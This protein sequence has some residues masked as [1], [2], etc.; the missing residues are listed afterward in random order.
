[1]EGLPSARRVDLPAPDP[2]ALG[3]SAELEA[4]LS[5]NRIF[6]LV[7][8]IFITSFNAARQ[9]GETNILLFPVPFG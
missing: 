5:S 6:F 9:S 8:I 7:A 3:A 2:D 4:S 1:V